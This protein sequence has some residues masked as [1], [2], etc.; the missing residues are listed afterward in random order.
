MTMP[1]TSIHWS[2]LLLSD[3]CGTIK[4]FFG[5]ATGIRNPVLYV[6]AKTGRDGGLWRDH[7]F[8]GVCR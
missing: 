4:F 6:G 1:T 8:G 5:R 2:T 3:W 7:G